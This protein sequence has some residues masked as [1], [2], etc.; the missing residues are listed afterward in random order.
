MQAG[1]DGVRVPTVSVVVPTHR[2]LLLLH[3]T[4][5]SILNQ[6]V[7]D[8]ELIIVFDGADDAV[9]RSVAAIGDPRIRTIVNPVALGVSRARNAGLSMSVAP[10]VAFCDDD[11]LWAPDKLAR[12]LRALSA[13]PDARWCAVSE[14]RLHED[15]RLG[16]LVTC[17][18]AEEIPR[19]IRSANVIPGGG[20]G[21]LADREL[22][23][24]VGGFD[25]EMSMFA[26]WDL[27][28]RLS[29]AAGVAVA[30]EPRLVYRDHGT[31]MSRDMTG[32]EGELDR[33]RLKHGA[34]GNAAQVSAS[35]V[36]EWCYDRSVTTDDRRI[37]YRALRELLAHHRPS[38]IW[39]TA[40]VLRLAVPHG[41]VRRA[42]RAGHR[43]WENT[44]VH[45]WVSELLEDHPVH[46]PVDADVDA[47]ADADVDA[48][49]DPVGPD[50]R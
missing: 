12:Q 7:D 49:V 42:R 5:R 25:A 28:L 20:S 21:V 1:C 30:R 6:T 18:A 39:T 8:L 45:R 10:W 22:V 27:W 41:L 35:K 48:D 37:R 23:M 26:D 3:Q 2:R 9:E 29:K 34:D 4:V 33:L 15:G 32:V 36:R 17:P 50:S 43:R 19:R 46:D 47:E 14:V 24:S 11:D 44:D 38:P 13:S 40:A 31:A 16:A